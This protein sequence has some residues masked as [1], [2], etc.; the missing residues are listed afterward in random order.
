[1]R[2]DVLARDEVDVD[3]PPTSDRAATATAELGYYSAA[4]TDVALT[5]GV[6]LMLSP[7]L[8]EHYCAAGM[9]SPS[10]R[11]RTTSTWISAGEAFAWAAA[12]SFRSRAP[13]AD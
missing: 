3:V 12:L 11:C 6:H 8:F 1:M 7:T 10:G 5:G 9:L 13:P 2:R 4:G